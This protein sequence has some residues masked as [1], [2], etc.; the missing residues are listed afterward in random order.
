MRPTYNE[1]CP[2]KAEVVSSNLAG[3]AIFSPANYGTI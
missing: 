3:C 1:N 2:P